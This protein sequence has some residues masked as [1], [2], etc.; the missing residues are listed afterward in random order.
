[1]VG[2][3][4]HS[5]PDI[6][7]LSLEQKVGQ[8][9]MAG[10]PGPQ[11]DRGLGELITRYHFGGIILFAR[12]IT[13]PRQLAELNQSL[14]DLALQNGALPLFVSID[15]EGG[16]VARLVEGA[17][18]PPGNMGLAAAGRENLAY[19]AAALMAR[20]LRAV[21][22]NVNFAPV[23]DVNNNPANPVIGVRSYGES[24]ELVSRLGVEAVRGYQENGVMATGKHFPGH[25]D[26]A[27]DSHLALPTIPHSRARLEKVE[28]APFRAAMAAGLD[29]IMTAHITFPAIDPAPGRPAT[30]SR[31]VLTELLRQ[32]LGFAGLI[33]TDS[34]EMKA[35]ADNFGTEEAAVMAVQAG[36][37]I[38]LVSHSY[39]EQ[40]ASYQAIL[41]AARKGDIPLGQINES[42]QRILQLKARYGLFPGNNR[43][44]GLAARPHDLHHGHQNQG[45]TSF[46]GGKSQAGG[47]AEGEAGNS[48]P[49]VGTREQLD[50]VQKMYD[51]SIT[52]VKNES[53]ILP[54][55][56]GGRLLVVSPRQL[57]LTLVEDEVG[58]S[59]KQSL[60]RRGAQVTEVLIPGDI[61]PSL[62]EWE[63]ARSEAP[64]ADAVILASQNGHLVRGQMALARA[65]LQDN[66][67]LLLVALRNPYDLL[68]LPEAPVFLAA[69]GYR[70]QAMEALARV[71]FGEIKPQGRLPVDLPGL[72]PVGHGLTL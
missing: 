22:V 35:I 12:N 46:F 69:Y 31:P 32:E 18:V 36:A 24:P 59:L 49:G 54:L 72:F 10:F 40:V 7:Q 50:L 66:A 25:G 27:L 65:L 62:P 16:I 33:F 39:K 2:G 11:A 53:S 63:R 45:Y 14:Q 8:M 17:A 6:K 58:S 19:E 28:L 37:D 64:R 3:N 30:L 13:S 67:K 38:V 57:G 43:D 60:Q 55:A 52:L 15:Q 5:V 34:M 23:L 68:E 48:W 9:I 41:T 21:G 71:I 4:G 44:D 29:A 26:T 61:T 51:Q 56:K 47:R 20:Q 70:D 1:M 42:V